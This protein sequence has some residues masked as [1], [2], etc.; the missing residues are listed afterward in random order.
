MIDYNHSFTGSILCIISF[1][2]KCYFYNLAE[3]GNKDFINDTAGFFF[4]F[5]RERCLLTKSYPQREREIIF[6]HL[7]ICVLKIQI[8]KT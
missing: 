8:Y 1:E 7:N 6:P 5:L 3:A 4:F 2:I